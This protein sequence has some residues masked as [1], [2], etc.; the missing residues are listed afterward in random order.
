MHDDEKTVL[1]SPI[2]RL[3]IYLESIVYLFCLPPP[4]RTIHVYIHSHTYAGET[5]HIINNA[6]G[7]WW[8]AH[9]L[10]TG[11]E[12]YIPSNYVTPADYLQTQE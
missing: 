1:L 4:P 11:K 8:L 12:G 6:E 9:S 5:L 2:P 3:P 7:D 10:K